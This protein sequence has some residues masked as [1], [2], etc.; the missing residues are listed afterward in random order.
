[1]DPI[2]GYTESDT[3]TFASLAA[4]D[5]I[6]ALSAQFPHRPLELHRQSDDLG[7]GTNRV[8]LYR[9]RLEVRFY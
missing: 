3:A 7:R 1:M 9:E 2:N 6:N 8:M 5:E 4:F